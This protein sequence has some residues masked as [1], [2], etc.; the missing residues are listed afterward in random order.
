V[1]APPKQDGVCDACGGELY[2]RPDDTEET[3]KNRL[4][5]YFRQTLPLTDYYE[6]QGKLVEINGEQPVEGVTRDIVG[7]LL[8]APGKRGAA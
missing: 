4:D 3:A 7:T 8:V 5:V 2:Q 1:S 6:E